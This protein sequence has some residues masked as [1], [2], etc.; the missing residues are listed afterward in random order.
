MVDF[1]YQTANF[2]STFYFYPLT[3]IGLEKLIHEMYDEGD[4]EN[5]GIL[6]AEHTGVLLSEMKRLA[7]GEELADVGP[8]Y[9]TLVERGLSGSL[10]AILYQM[11]RVVDIPIFYWNE[12]RLRIRGKMELRAV[13]D[14]VRKITS[15]DEPFFF[16]EGEGF[17]VRKEK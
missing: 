3:R 13:I 8:L 16:P 5:G 6:P 15:Y 1:P 11:H 7:D 9:Q 17:G 2:I 4:E 10:E 14:L 12:T